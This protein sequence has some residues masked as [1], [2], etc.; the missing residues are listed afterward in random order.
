[1]EL[2]QGLLVVQFLE[3]L[4]YDGA[5][6]EQFDRLVAICLLRLEVLLLDD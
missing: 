4:D 6:L 5:Y 3:S 2:R 1:M